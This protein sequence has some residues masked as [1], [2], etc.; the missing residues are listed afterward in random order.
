MYLKINLFIGLFD[1]FEIESH[2]PLDKSHF[3]KKYY[4]EQGMK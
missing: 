1:F 4:Q 2:I 3:L